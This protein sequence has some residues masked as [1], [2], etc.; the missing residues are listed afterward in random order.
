MS[1]EQQAQDILSKAGITIN[2]SAPYDMQ[3]HNENLYTRIFSGGSL[4]LGESYMDG[5]WDCRDLSE[6]FSRLC[7]ISPHDTETITL[8]GVAWQSFISRIVNFQSSARAFQVGKQHYDIGN[9]LYMRMLDKR[10]I[11][12]CGYW[13]NAKNLDEAQE[14]KLDLICRKIGL[15]EGDTLLDIGCGWGGLAKYA[16]EKYGAR[17]TG[18]TVS[19]EQATFATEHTQGLPVTIRLQDWRELGDE[20]FTHVVSVGMFEH[21]GPKNYIAFMRKVQEVLSDEGLFL[22]H[23]IGANRDGSFNDPWIDTYIFPNG[24]LPSV[25]EV[26]TAFSVIQQGRPTFILEDWHNF[27]TDYDK[28]LMAW[29]HN[30]EK[31]WSHIPQYDERFQR[32]W[33]YYLLMCAGLFRSR[34]TQLWQIVLS[35]KG[36]TGGYASIR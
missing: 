20:T 27:G 21:V 23:T 10:M 31:V 11:Y 4:A 8:V 7:T 14:H 12:S 35:K 25:R 1:C 16:A 5:W 19:K 17:V 32:M 6:F 30:I 9:D 29:Y 24:V 3:V 18:I 33:R 28:T 13:K 34:A 22:L 15:T 2:G 36:R 26:V